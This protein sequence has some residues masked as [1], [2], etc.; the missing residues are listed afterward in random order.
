[1]NM[2]TTSKRYKMVA[3]DLDGTLLRS[4]HTVSETSA[5]YLR[6]LHDRGFIVTLATGRSA[7][8]TSQAIT[9][10]NLT[11]PTA[12]AEGFPVLCFNGAKGISVSKKNDTEEDETGTT[13]DR[14]ENPMLDGRLQVTQLFHFPVPLE[15]ARETL[16]LAKELGC[17]TNY[18]LGHDIIANP[19]TDAHYK[20]T[21]SYSELTGIKFTYCTDNYEGAMGRG[22]PSKLNILCE[23]GQ[24]DDVTAKAKALLDGRATVIQIAPYFVEIVREDV[25]KGNG[26][27]KMCDNLGVGLNECISFGDGDNDIEFIQNSGLGFAMSNARSNVKAIAD[28]VTEFTNNEDGVICELKKLEKNGMLHFSCP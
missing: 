15:V 26:L 5:T 10:L 8:G 16:A 13:T 23:E 11:F 2:A 19:L 28:E 21:Q 25:C 3:L 17:V 14:H 12:R 6:S 20:S 27:A 9:D 4:D 18:Y 22:L 24:I 1:L 7:A